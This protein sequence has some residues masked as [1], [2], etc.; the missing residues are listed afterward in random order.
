MHKKTATSVI[1]TICK[2]LY[3]QCR[4]GGLNHHDAEDVTH[5]ALIKKWLDLEPENP[6]IK[7]LRRTARDL[8]KNLRRTRARR[9]KLLEHA[10]RTL[11]RQQNPIGRRILSPEKA[12]EQDETRANLLRAIEELPKDQ[13]NVIVLRYFEFFT[14]K[15]IAA[16]LEILEPTARGIRS[17]ACKNLEKLLLQKTDENP[18]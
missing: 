9:Q 14:Y 4:Y 8:V 18:A 1:T 13:R 5:T 10:S 17:R 11:F 16:R 6:D 7:K 2:K 12:A 3:S 15:E